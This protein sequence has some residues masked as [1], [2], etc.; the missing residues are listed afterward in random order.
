[1]KKL[2]IA[3]LMLGAL[4]GTSAWAEVETMEDGNIR[5]YGT[6]P[7]ESLIGIEVYKSP[8]S[9]IDL[10][11][12]KQDEYLSVIKYYNQM[13]SKNDGSYEFFVD[14]TGESGEYIVYTGTTDENFAAESF[15]YVTDSDFEDIAIR[16]NNADVSEIKGILEN[17]SNYGK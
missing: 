14:L 7:S 15:A 4:S 6:A 1:M 10:D 5:I 12:L 13:A 16:A 3:V 11:N 2:L 9:R 8:N 17:D